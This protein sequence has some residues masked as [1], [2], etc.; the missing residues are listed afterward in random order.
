[1]PK[2]CLPFVYTTSI[3]WKLKVLSLR[4]RSS[5]SLQKKKSSEPS[6]VFN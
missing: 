4:F 1:M 5:A 2:E 3:P 6:I